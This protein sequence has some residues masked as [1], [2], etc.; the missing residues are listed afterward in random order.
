MR[1]RGKRYK[2]LES[3]IDKKKEYSL[4]DAIALSKSLASA[5]FDETVVMAVRL[6]VKPQ[7]AD[8][9]VRGSVVMPKGIGK[10][11]KILVFAK[12]EKEKEAL[13][14]GADFVGA[15]NM[16]E[17]ITGGWMEF[18]RIVATP[19]MMGAVGKLG[20]VLGPRGLM[21]NPKSGTVTFELAR[22]IKEIQA[23]KVEFKTEKAGIVHVPIGKASF[24]PE[25]LI[26][27]ARVILETIV[28]MKPA[29]AKGHYLKSI[30]VSTTMGPGVKADSVQIS[31]LMNV[32]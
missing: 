16:I 12:G 22:A 17:K 23:G 6:G 24:K 13:E 31:K 1:K 8:Q 2:N 14:A 29:S 18:D 25:D 11:T 26:E 10:K 9:M 3:K 21:P 27:N 30:T 5:K 20:K 32:V 7:Q 4:E 15:E 28:R 19:D